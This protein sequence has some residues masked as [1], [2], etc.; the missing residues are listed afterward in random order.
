MAGFNK[1]SIH[2]LG[3]NGLIAFFLLIYIAACGGGGGSEPQPDSADTVAPV[4]TLNGENPLTLIQ[5]EVYSEPGATAVD[6]TDGS[7][8]VIITGTVD[9]NTVGVYTITYTATDAAGNRGEETRTVNVQQ[10]S[11]FI[12]RWKTDNPGTTNNNQIKIG[13]AGSGYDYS[14]DWGDGITENNISGDAIHTYSAP[15]TYTVSITGS[16][17]RIFF[18]SNDYDNEKLLSIEQWGG[19]QWQSMNKAFYQCTNLIGNFSDAPDLSQVTDLSHMFAYARNFNQSINNWNVSNI[20]H[21]NNMFERADVFDQELNGWDVSSVIDMSWLFYRALSFNQNLSSW[22][23]SA[24]TSMQGTFHVA[25]DFN[26]DISNWD[27]S[28]VTNMESMFFNAVA[29]N[30]DLS[31]W[32][33]AKVT[34]MFRMFKLASSFDQDLSN[35]ELS[36]VTTMGEM[37]NDIALST[38]NYN[39]LLNGLSVQTLQNNVVFG[40]GNSRYSTSSQGARDTLTNVYNWT[41][42]DGGIE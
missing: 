30:Q 29:F 14:V 18:D 21:M 1:T 27:V 34:D 36:K 32:N 40:A 5:S 19:Q 11:A 20:T 6:E 37:F 16:F 42:T 31:S 4:I 35:W 33:V 25:S 10:T 24:V 26:Q 23:V 8:D 41:V 9:V 28:S 17:P 13:T 2:T 38:S 7:V 15:G 22:D 39:A 3:S 12:T